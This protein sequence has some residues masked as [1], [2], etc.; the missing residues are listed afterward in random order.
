MSLLEW[1]MEICQIQVWRS[2]LMS[3]MIA[4]QNQTH[5][6]TAHSNKIPA[7]FHDLFYQLFGLHFIVLWQAAFN[8]S[9]AAISAFAKF[10]KYLTYCNY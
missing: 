4:A 2:G 3:A 5:K 7:K 10:F 9:N 6:H 8:I 1:R